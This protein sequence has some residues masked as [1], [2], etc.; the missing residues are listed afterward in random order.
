MSIW[1][2]HSGDIFWYIPQ[3]NTDQLWRPFGPAFGHLGVLDVVLHAL[4]P[5][6][7][8]NAALDS[9]K[10]NKKFTHKYKNVHQ[11][12]QNLLSRNPFFP[13]TFLRIF[14]FSISF[15]N[16]F[17]NFYFRFFRILRM[18]LFRI[19]LFELV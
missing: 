9:D 18:F 8:G 10:F 19:F 13:E 3:G 6:D 14:L 11:E 4:R 16:L 15:R 2:S 17:Q 5:H 1:H 7:P 12:I